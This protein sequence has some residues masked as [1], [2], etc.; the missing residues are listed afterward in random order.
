MAE[1]DADN[2]VAAERCVTTAELGHHCAERKKRNAVVMVTVAVAIVIIVVAFISTRK[3]P[4]GPSTESPSFAPTDNRLLVI[5]QA[6]TASTD[7]TVTIAD[8]GDLARMDSTTEELQFPFSK[9]NSKVIAFKGRLE[10][11]GWSGRSE[12]GFATLVH[13]VKGGSRLFTASFTNG[14]DN[15]SVCPGSHGLHYISCRKLSEFPEILELEPP[16][17]RRNLL[18]DSNVVPTQQR[19]PYLSIRTGEVSSARDQL[20]RRGMADLSV[21]TVFFLWSHA[22][23]CRQ[24]GLE[25]GC[26]TNSST[27]SA[28]EIHADLCIKSFND[29]AS[30]SGVKV[31]LQ[32][33]KNYGRI[34]KYNETNVYNETEISMNDT[35]Y[36]MRQGPHMNQEADLYVMIT[37]HFQGTAPSQPRHCGSGFLNSEPSRRESFFVVDISCSVASLSF[38]QLV[39]QNFGCK[40]DRGTEDD[41]KCTDDYNY[42]HR[43]G[44]GRF[45][46]IMDCMN[47]SPDDYNYGYRDPQGRYRDI[48]A[49]PCQPGQ[50]DNLPNETD[51][52]RLP[53]FSNDLGYFYN[54]SLPVGSNHSS[55][56][57]RMNDVAAAIRN[58]TREPTRNPSRNPSPSPTPYPDPPRVYSSSGNLYGG[59]SLEYKEKVDNQFYKGLQKFAFEVHSH[60]SVRGIAAKTNYKTSWSAFFGNDYYH[61]EVT[62]NGVDLPGQRRV[63]FR[64]EYFFRRKG[65]YSKQLTSWKGYTP[66]LKGFYFKFLSGEEYIRKVAVFLGENID[67]CFHDMNVGSDNI[68]VEVYIAY[69]PNEYVADSGSGWVQGKGKGLKRVLDSNPP[70][71]ATPVL[72][73]FGVEFTDDGNIWGNGDDNTIKEISAGVYLSDQ[74]VVWG[75]ATLSDGENNRGLQCEWSYAMITSY[76]LYR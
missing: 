53:M 20:R 29:A 72:R 43:D 75:E 34:Y 23:E 18:F 63:K 6:G 50:C 16:P 17:T 10:E 2:A 71:H 7:G 14:D 47:Q 42:G 62:I 55:C 19:D 26:K 1:Q 52:T 30:S 35:L 21:V 46:D 74:N 65:C 51:C 58:P 37:D 66:V 54:D 67:I 68:D 32:P 73:G 41:C 76:P 8:V 13:A 70:N 61:Y 60:R 33:Y 22:A 40:H 28:M 48:M 56:A 39:G 31:M 15:C 69:V 27:T 24:F 25:P 64:T 59:G 45:E 57:R 49:L 3:Q 4:I 44:V 9:D 5:K 11:D 12:Q 38:A 36:E